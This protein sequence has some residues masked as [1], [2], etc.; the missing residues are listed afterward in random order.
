MSGKVRR[1]RRIGYIIG[2]GMIVTN[3]IGRGNYDVKGFWFEIVTAAIIVTI[4][5]IVE[6]INIAYDESKRFN[7]LIIAIYL[8]DLLI[9]IVAQIVT[10]IVI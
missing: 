10:T 5:T 7:L 9:N 4:F 6:L 8:L 1:L 3:L 2:L